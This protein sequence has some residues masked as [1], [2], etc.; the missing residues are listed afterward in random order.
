M[1]SNLSRNW[2]QYSPKTC[3]PNYYRFSLLKQNNTFLIHGLWV[4]ECDEC[5]TCGYPSFCNV[6]NNNCT[7]NINSIKTLLPALQSQWY[8]GTSSFNTSSI[9]VIETDSTREQCMCYNL[10]SDQMGNFSR[11]SKNPHN[12]LLAHEWCKHGLC[13]NLT[14]FQYFN[15]SLTLYQSLID[16]DL[17]KLCNYKQSEC[18]FIVDSYFNIKNQS[19]SCGNLIH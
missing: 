16:N 14:E 18:Y 15:I 2:Y 17:I 12:T 1:V 13:T 9:E 5:P 4:E 3:T 19:I 10:R 6:V 8:P 11:P 7:F